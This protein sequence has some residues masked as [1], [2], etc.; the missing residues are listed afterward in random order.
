MSGLCTHDH[1]H[2][3]CAHRN[4]ILRFACINSLLQ[5]VYPLARG[6]GYSLP[7]I[8]AHSQSTDCVSLPSG[9]S[10]LASVVRHDIP[11]LEGEIFTARGMP[12]H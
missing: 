11:S 3:R 9:P 4:E 8:Q 7:T 10:V 1:V 2:V 6:G 12:E 5:V